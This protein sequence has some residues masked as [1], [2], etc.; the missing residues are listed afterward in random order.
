MSRQPPFARATWPHLCLALLVAASAF[1]SGCNRR[2]ETPPTANQPALR[3]L[4][5]AA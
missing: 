4:P 3:D 1:A 2:D 5:S